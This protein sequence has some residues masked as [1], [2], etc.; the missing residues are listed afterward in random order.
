MRSIC[1][2]I[3]CLPVVSSPSSVPLDPYLKTKIS[4]KPLIL[5]AQ[6]FPT[7]SSGS[8]AEDPLQQQAALSSNIACN[9]SKVTML[10]QVPLKNYD[11]VPASTV[12]P[13]V[14]LPTYQL[15]SAQGHGRQYTFPQ[16]NS[17]AYID[18]LEELYFS[19]AQ[20]ALGNLFCTL[21]YPPTLLAS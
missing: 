20:T 13:L 15:S 16:I 4:C 14:Y 17:T 2:T 6:D 10:W 5:H 19:V 1:R 12:Q 18:A 11:T 21:G 8:R 3:A 7:Q 9:A